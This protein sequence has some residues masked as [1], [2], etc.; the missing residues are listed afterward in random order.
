MTIT[1][2][3]EKARESADSSLPPEGGSV[4]VITDYVVL[5]SKTC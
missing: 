5:G 3:R 4:M 1:A 2:K